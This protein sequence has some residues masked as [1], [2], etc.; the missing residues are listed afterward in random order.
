MKHISILI[1]E[2]ATMTSVDGSLQ[3]FSRINDFLKYSGKEPFYSLELIGISDYTVLNDGLYNIKSNKVLNEIKKTDLIII[4]IICGDFT[5]MI[6]ANHEFVGWIKNQYHS[7][8][9]IASLCVGSFFLASTGLLDGKN[10]A[11]HWAS[12]NDFQ[13]MFPKVNVIDDTIITEENGIYTSGGT[14]SYLNLLL[15][16]IEKH[17]GREMSVLASKMFEIDIERKNQNQFAIF[18]GQKRH[19]DIEVLKAQEFIENNPDKK[20]TVDEVCL[21]FGIGRRT[22]ERRFKK[23][24]KNS[25]MEYMHRVKVESVKK[26]LEIGRKTVNEIIFEVGYNDINAFREVFK[27]ITGMSPVEYRKKYKI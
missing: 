15:Y 10:C 16:I 24:T 8:S 13:N 11:T 27:K 21:K 2:G 18:M 19:D 12:K 9:E 22:F 1:L 5:K 6:N 4:P 23:S 3:L 20:I 26:Q 25:F 17:L 7:G 14:Y